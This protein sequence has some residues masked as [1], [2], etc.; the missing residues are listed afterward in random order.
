MKPHC[1][2]FDESYS[3]HYYRIDTMK[4]F[5][6]YQADCMIIVGT[7]LATTGAKILT[8]SMLDKEDCP[9][10]EVNMESSINR[11]NNI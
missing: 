3:E 7:A 2:F 11:G 1:M 4:R 9:V 6:N 5:A 10:I 8:S